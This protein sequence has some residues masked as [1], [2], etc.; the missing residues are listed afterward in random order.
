M[1]ELT[2]GRWAGASRAALYTATAD[3]TS[4]RRPWADVDHAQ[5]AAE[6]AT[7]TIYWVDG[8]DDILTLTGPGAPAFARTLRERVQSSVVHSEIVMLPGGAQVRVA[9]RRDEDGGLLSQVIGVGA[10]DLADPDV[11]ALV[12]AAEARVRSAA[13]LR[14]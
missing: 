8:H 13:G 6:T 12:D 10:V 4:Q 3:G 5:L 9:L 1:T 11:A 7:L 2:D 14:A